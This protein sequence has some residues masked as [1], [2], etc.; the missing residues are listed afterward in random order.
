MLHLGLGQNV[1]LL[2]ELGEVFQLLLLLFNEVVIFLET[3][4]HDLLLGTS[5][6]AG[7]HGLGDLLVLFLLSLLEQ[8]QFLEQGPVDVELD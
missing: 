3:L 4:Q 7:C 5:G 1:L 2:L 8:L 6:L